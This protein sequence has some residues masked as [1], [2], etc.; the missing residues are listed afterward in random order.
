[1]KQERDV[2]QGPVGTL[3]SGLACPLFLPLYLLWRYSMVS[4]YI[5]L[6]QV[7]EKPILYY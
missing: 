6:V 3:K 1:M 2:S 5:V 4:Y 7:N